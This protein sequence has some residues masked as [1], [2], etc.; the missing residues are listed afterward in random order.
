MRIKTLILFLLT[1]VTVVSCYD[2]SEINESL[3][4]LESR[5]LRL[6]RICELMNGDISSLQTIIEALQQKD[7]V[8]GTTVIM[9]NGK[10][11]G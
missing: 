3:Q 7:F 5:I 6:E 1:M 2:D 10:E 11:V 4:N 8:T 9:E